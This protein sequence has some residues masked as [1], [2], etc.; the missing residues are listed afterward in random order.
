[1]EC[2]IIIY[3]MKYYLKYISK[4]IK[5]I[6][7]DRF[8]KEIYINSFYLVSGMKLSSH[9]KKIINLKKIQ[10]SHNCGKRKIRNWF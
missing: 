4:K 5:K 8:F 1:M 2:N 7:S 6:Q 9:E 10:L 3:I